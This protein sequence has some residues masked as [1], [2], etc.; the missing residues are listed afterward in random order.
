MGPVNRLASGV[1]VVAIS[2]VSVSGVALNLVG[3]DIELGGERG[4]GGRQL[5]SF[6]GD[7][8][9]DGLVACRERMACALLGLRNAG[10]GQRTGG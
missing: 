9:G 10:G 6:G 7:L 8:V 4:V 5:A 2:R 1:V 3:G